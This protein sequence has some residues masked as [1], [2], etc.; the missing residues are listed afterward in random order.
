MRSIVEDTEAPSR[1]G[2]WP[3]WTG[4]N[5]DMSR[6]ATRWADGD[7][8]Q[9]PGRPCSCCS[10][11]RGT[12]VL[13]QGDEIGQDRHRR[14]P[15]PDAG[16]SRRRLLAGL[17]RTRRHAHAHAVARTDPAEASPSPERSPGCPSATRRACNVE[18]QRSDPDS[19]LNLAR[20][21]IALRRA[22]PELQP[23]AR[24]GR[25]GRPGSVGLEPGTAR[26]WS[27]ST[28]RT[29]RARG[30]GRL[31]H[32]ADRHRPPPRRGPGRRDAPGEGWEG[33]VVERT[34]R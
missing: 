25:C 5:H 14:A 19:M 16:P 10:C 28:C 17:R 9:G 13:Y 30:R 2:A 3:A 33:V 1:T 34:D 18:D 8:A 20:D 12:P 15:R 32:G 4:S 21:L 29:G 6:F 27:C 31:G 23:R 26:W 11:L 24:T 7:A 22:T